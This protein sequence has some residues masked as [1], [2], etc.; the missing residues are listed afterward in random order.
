MSDESPRS[1]LPW[2]M[3][4]L[5]LVIGGAK[6]DAARPIIGRILAVAIPVVPVVLGVKR[7][8]GGNAQLEKTASA[9]GWMTILGAEA[10][11]AGA[12]F[13][14]QLLTDALPYA[15]VAL[16]VALVGGLLAH[17]LEAR[18]HGKARF[19]GYVG[20]AAGYGVFISG[21]VGK[22]PFASVFGAFF[23]GVLSG[24]AALLAGELLSRLFVKSSS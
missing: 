11:V 24:G 3:A 6:L 18:S 14:L 12:F 20:I 15:R 13:H 22:D 4:A 7:L 17:L 19:A 2:V 10:C 5:V 21:H 1:A 8:E 16:Y 9:V 23:I